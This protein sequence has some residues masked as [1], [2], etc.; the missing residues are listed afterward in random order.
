MYLYCLL[1]KVDVDSC[2]LGL[3]SFLSR[4]VELSLTKCMAVFVG[5]FCEARFV[6]LKLCGKLLNISFEN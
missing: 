1:V 6:D 3:R 2:V 4:T 5:A